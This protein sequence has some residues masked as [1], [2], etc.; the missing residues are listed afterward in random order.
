VRQPLDGASAVCVA[1]VHG[2]PPPPRQKVCKVFGTKD[3]RLDFDLTSFAKSKSPAWAGLRFSPDLSLSAVSMV[4]MGYVMVLSLS[5][6]GLSRR[7]T[8]SVHRRFVTHRDPTA[9]LAFRWPT[10]WEINDDKRVS[11]YVLVQE[12]L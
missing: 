2:L 12:E 4:S 5:Y 7:F 3:I 10:S 11:Q 1:V 6:S 9:L 8:R